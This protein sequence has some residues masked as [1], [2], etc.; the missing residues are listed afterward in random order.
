MTPQPRRRR[1][2]C[3]SSASVGLLTGAS[4]AYTVGE[5]RGVFLGLYDILSRGYARSEAP[6][7]RFGE[8]VK[9]G[10]GQRTRPAKSSK[11][12]YSHLYKII[13]IV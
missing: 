3:R 7:T 8:V 2:V 1:G 11:I 13:L 10:D 5:G 12:Y 9:N 6:E 4:G